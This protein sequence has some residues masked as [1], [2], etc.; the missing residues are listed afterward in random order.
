MAILRQNRSDATPVTNPISACRK[1][2]LERR[3]RSRLQAARAY[4]QP[5]IRNSARKTRT[6]G[7]KATATTPSNAQSRPDRTDETAIAARAA[8]K[9][10]LPTPLTTRSATRASQGSANRAITGAR[11]T[12]YGGWTSKKSR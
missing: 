5:S 6:A 9:A 12:K 2:P 10:R 3:N 1:R 11:S 8:T 7:W 4:P